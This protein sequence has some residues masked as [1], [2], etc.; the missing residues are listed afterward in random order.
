MAEPYAPPNAALSDARAG[1]VDPSLVTWTHVI[2]ELHAASIVVA[3]VGA[4]TIVGSFLFSIP[5]LAAIILNYVKR[6][7]VR[8]TYLESHFTWQIRTFWY[9][10]VWGLVG[11]VVW[12]VLAIVLIGFV[13]GPAILGITGLWVCYR[14]VR[15]WL[16][17]RAGDR[18][19]ASM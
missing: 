16:A 5:S 12:V 6:G 18:V 1:S 3:V 17:L 8:G 10:L 7:D 19:S 13:L 14:I 4:A 2:Y 11:I 15:G 9:A